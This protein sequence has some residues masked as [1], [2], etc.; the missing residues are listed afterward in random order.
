MR[1]GVSLLV[2]ALCFAVC[3]EV[4]LASDQS[5]WGWLDELSG[6]GPFTGSSV[7]LLKLCK[8]REGITG[9]SIRGVRNWSVGT[10]TNTTHCFWADQR[11]FHVDKDQD[12]PAIQANLYDQGL[13]VTWRRL[14]SAGV[15]VGLIRFNSEGPTGHVTT[16]RLT[17][18]PVRLTVNPLNVFSFKDPASFS[19]RERVWSNILSV[20]QAYYKV[21]CIPGKLSGANFGAPTS[22]FTSGGE[23]LESYGIQLNLL[24][25]L[26]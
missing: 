19:E 14:V 8:D 1:R 11:F 25:L 22:T 2:F 6:P 15:G 5:W 20:P 26:R 18:T 4:A 10:P 21:V 17:L 9:T 7:E 24:E 12:F 13:S 3:G 16:N 23:C